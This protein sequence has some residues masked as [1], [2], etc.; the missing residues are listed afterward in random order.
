MT[1]TGG[2]TS[3][4]ITHIPFFTVGHPKTQVESPSVLRF[5]TPDLL[6]IAMVSQYH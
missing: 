5:S 6:T 3:S 4:A 1:Q 2:F